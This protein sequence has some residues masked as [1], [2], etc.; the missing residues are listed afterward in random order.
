MLEG[1]GHCLENAALENRKRKFKSEGA[2][3]LSPSS[4]QQNL[5]KRAQKGKG[6]CSH[7]H[8]A[9]SIA[10][11]PTLRFALFTEYRIDAPFLSDTSVRQLI[12]RKS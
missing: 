8:N 9:L 2:D 7:G 6:L 5:A 11:T 4:T 10:G 3:R 12:W 1:K